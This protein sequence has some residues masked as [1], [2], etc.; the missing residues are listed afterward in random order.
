MAEDLNYESVPSSA[1][2]LFKMLWQL[3]NWFRI[4]TYVEL[5]AFEENW[6]VAF[7]TAS[8]PASRSLTNDKQLHH[9]ATP[10]EHFLSYVSFGQLC[11]VITSDTYWQHFECYFPPRAITLAKLDEVKNVRNRIAHFRQP[12]S[13]D[14]DRIRLLLNDMEPYIHKFCARYTDNEMRHIPLSDPLLSELEQRWDDSGYGVELKYPRGWLYDPEPNRFNPKISAELLYLPHS[15]SDRSTAS[16][17]IYRLNLHAK[18]GNDINSERF[19]EET[20][21]LHQ[22]ILHLIISPLTCSISVTLP[23]I[24]G[25][26]RALLLI[27]R[28]LSFALSSTRS[29]SLPNQKTDWPEHVLGPAHLL[30]IYDS[31]YKGPIFELE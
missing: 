2:R 21:S 3:E 13:R 26:D 7:Q 25:T 1:V 23:A 9:M 5:R 20:R 6:E 29:P 4:I 12:N 11:S 19:T 30:S 8:Q 22:N 15:S 17:L 27:F 14:E 31:D 16:G 28:F 24:T 10:H 18:V